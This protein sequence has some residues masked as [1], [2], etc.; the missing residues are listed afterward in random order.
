MTADPFTQTMTPPRCD[1]LIRHARFRR[2]IREP[3][4]AAWR[5][6]VINSLNTL[7]PAH[8]VQ[9]ASE[10]VLSDRILGAQVAGS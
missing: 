5:S 6:A 8:N 2:A 7:R 4:N 9:P 3:A 1:E 10:S